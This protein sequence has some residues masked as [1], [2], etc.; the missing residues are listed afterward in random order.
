MLQI[1]TFEQYLNTRQRLNVLTHTNKL[2][3]KISVFSPIHG[4][5]S[6]Y[7][8]AIAIR[9]ELKLRSLHLVCNYSLN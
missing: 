1:E 2:I 4:T 9:L 7:N 5:K 8:K 6:F 3:M